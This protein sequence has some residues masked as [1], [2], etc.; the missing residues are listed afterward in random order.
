M[1]VQHQ[2]HGLL[3]HAEE[4]FERAMVAGWDIPLALPDGPED[5]LQS[6]PG[7]VHWA[8]LFSDVQHEVQPVTQG[9]RLTLTYHVFASPA[10]Q[11]PKPALDLAAMPLGQALHKALADPDFLP[12]GGELGFACA[13]LYPHTGKGFTAQLL[14]GADR[15][16]LQTAAALQLPAVL[17]PV[18][19][20]DQWD[21]CEKEYDDGGPQGQVCQCTECCKADG[22]VTGLYQGK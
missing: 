18:W 4:P 14:K 9:H 5:S 13:H 10:E 7:A 15:L 8:F 21:F 22:R 17:R 1:G 6:Q 12:E 2:N 16:V 3:L 19:K 11:P 20:S